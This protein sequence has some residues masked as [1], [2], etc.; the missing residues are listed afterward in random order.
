MSNGVLEIPFLFGII[1]VSVLSVFVTMFRFTIV[2]FIVVLLSFVLFGSFAVRG[3]RIE[4]PSQPDQSIRPLAPPP[5]QTLRRQRIREGTAFK[6][7]HVFFQQTG[8][9][10][11]LYTVDDNQRFTCLE[12]LALERILTALEAKPERRYWKIEGEF[13]EFRGENFVKIRRAVIAQ[14]PESAGPISP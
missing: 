10:I 8:D 4:P 9:R 14:A 2:S 13:T 7:M 6:N 11:V 3:Q 1:I 12:N 5:K